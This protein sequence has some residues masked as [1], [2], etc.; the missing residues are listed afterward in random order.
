MATIR[1]ALLS[2]YDKTGIID[3]ARTLVENGVMLISTGGTFSVLQKAG[4]P[5]KQV[6]EITGFPEMLD[7][8]VKTLHP[9]IHGG[10]LAR[11]DQDA[12]MQQISEHGIELIDLLV[13]SLYPFEETVAAGAT[14]GECIEQIDIGGPSMLRSAAKNHAA[15]TVVCDP[16][17]YDS[18][19]RMIVDHGD[20]TPEL[21]KILAAKVF[22]LT[23]RYD[24]AIATFLL[25]Q[26][27]SSGGIPAHLLISSEKTQH[28][29]YGENPHQPAA[30]YGSFFDAFD[31]LHGKELSYN[32]I[33]D[34]DA[35]AALIEE[36]DSPAAAIIKHTNP[37][38]CA[39]GESLLEAYSAALTTD[40]ASA[41]GGII[42][43]NREVDI[44][45]A[46]ML[47]EMFSEVIIAPSFAEDALDI[48]RRK[49]DRRLIRLLARRP[50]PLP[51]QVK[52]VRNGYL[53]QMAD[54]EPENPK[55]WEVVSRRQPTEDERTALEFAWRIVKHVK[56]N[57]VVYTDN[58]RTL[59]I[60]AGQ[61]SRVDSST[62]AAL[63]AT[64]ASLSLEGSVVASDAFFPFADG[65]LAA[66]K[67]G[68]TAVI[69]PGGSVR[70]EEVIAAADEHNISM[71]FTGTRHFK[72]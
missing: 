53:C 48:L 14:F 69:Q 1:R 45:L 64:N 65:L 58:R 26:T 57:A 59:G 27:E 23:A 31:K 2:V 63:K 8:R 22:A 25:E 9:M 40:P 72:H 30:L 11:R 37:C 60:G 56:S 42:A 15:V 6:Q 49:R 29:R 18:V 39:I 17:D 67:A 35:A 21:R 33:V 38:G 70:D 20:T 10:L 12:H 32:N 24:N 19:A 34:I 28:L 62:I 51:L 47:N 55:A 43:L 44:E 13:I 36:F 3:F 4:L 5:V 41:Y 71:I 16:A 54:A 50:G 66:V 68:A 46:E 52:S 7:G 61:M